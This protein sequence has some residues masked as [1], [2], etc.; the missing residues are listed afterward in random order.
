MLHTFKNIS[1]I[2]MELE[3]NDGT[4]IISKETISY[5]NVLQC[6]FEDDPEIG[7]LSFESMSVETFVSLMRWLHGEEVII[8]DDMINLT[9]FFNMVE[10]YK[11]RFCAAIADYLL[12]EPRQLP[13]EF[14]ISLLKVDPG[15]LF[16]F[17]EKYFGD[18]EKA[19]FK[20]FMTHAKKLGEDTEFNGKLIVYDDPNDH[21][22]IDNF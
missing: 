12:A 18:E 7:K 8:D 3:F 16:L 6:A 19:Y 10:P 14:Y 17:V 21:Q 22:R 5:F 1:Y 2:K 11:T 9:N 4:I 15:R 13:R 20:T